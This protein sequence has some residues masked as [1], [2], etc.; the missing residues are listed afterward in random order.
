MS[1]VQPGRRPVL[2]AIDAAQGVPAADLAGFGP[3]AMANVD[4]DFNERPINY[5]KDDPKTL[6]ERARA[7]SQVVLDGLTEQKAKAEDRIAKATALAAEQ[8]ERIERD[9]K[10]ELADANADLAQIAICKAAYDHLVGDLNKA[11]PK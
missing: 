9:L 11:A 10:L 6:V 4:T 2:Q 1:N 7:Q 8:I 5:A 3:D